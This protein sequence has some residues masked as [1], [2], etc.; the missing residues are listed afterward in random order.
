MFHDLGLIVST[1]C[2]KRAIFLRSFA[3]MID[4][5]LPQNSWN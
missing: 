5:K 4:T 2:E 1:K 3:L